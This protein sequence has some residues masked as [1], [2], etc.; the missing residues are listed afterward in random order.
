M[1]NDFCNAGFGAIMYGLAFK[2][3]ICVFGDGRAVKVF[4]ATDEE[5]DNAHSRKTIAILAK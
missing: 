2:G 4:S 5:P 1:T 3:R